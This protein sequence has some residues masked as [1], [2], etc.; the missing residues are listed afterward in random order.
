MFIAVLMI[1][2]IFT[3]FAGAVAVSSTDYQP[4]MLP[5]YIREMDA[6]KQWGISKATFIRARKKG[7]P[8]V[9]HGAYVA[10]LVSD[11][12]AHFCTPRTWKSDKEMTSVASTEV[13]KSANQTEK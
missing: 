12:Q 10:Y 7:L 1:L 3:G 6:I 9:R 8:F 11:L 13:H 5:K 2:G 4:P